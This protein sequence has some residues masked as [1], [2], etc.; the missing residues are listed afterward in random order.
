MSI[1][2]TVL[3]ASLVLIASSAFA[4][5]VKPLHEFA[6]S[7]GNSPLAVDVMRFSCGSLAGVTIDHAVASIK[8][9]VPE[10]KPQVNVKLAKWNGYTC[11]GWTNAVGD[12]ID[13][14]ADPSAEVEK[15]GIPAVNG[16]FCAMVYKT[17]SNQNTGTGSKTASGA[18]NYE[19]DVHCGQEGVAD[20]PD[21]TL[22]G[23][24]ING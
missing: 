15:S 6:G 4:G 7:L 20:H 11:T 17:A 16:K 9:V 22:D 24:F 3:A 2:K 14:D 21:P 13:D 23:Y 12:L 10:A 8:D 19:I 18:E 1:K 5:D